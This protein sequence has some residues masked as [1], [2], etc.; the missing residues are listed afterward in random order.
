[1]FLLYQPRI[2]IRSNMVKG[3]EA[4]LRWRHPEHGVMLPAAFLQDAEESGCIV[5]IGQLVV[6]HAC[7]FLQRLRCSGY[8]DV[9]VSINFSQR[10]YAQHDF[11]QGIVAR[12]DRCGLPREC[13]QIELRADGLMRNPG[14]GREVA[15]QLHTMGLALSVDEFGDGVSDLNYLEQLSPRQI[16]MAKA[17]V[18]AIVDGAKRSA[19]AKS[20]I[21]IG[22]NLGMK[23][24]GEAVQTRAQMEFLRAHGC[25]QLQGS[26]F[27]EPVSADAA[28]AML[29][30]RKV[31]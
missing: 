23:V 15:S 16:Q 14:L 27:S 19:V 1:M 26:W 6:E 30:G 10:E 18:H 11:V 7:A 17:T 5:R 22:H 25:D 24:V 2:D 28:E 20:V 8:N 9:Q 12:L 13:L 31:V 29:R 3:F 4:L 21:D